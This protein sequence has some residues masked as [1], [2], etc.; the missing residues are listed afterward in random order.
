MSSEDSSVQL[1]I[2]AEIKEYFEIEKQLKTVKKT[3][4]LLNKRR[5]E[6]AQILTNC[7]K[8][9]DVNHFKTD[10]GYISIEEKE[11]S[12]S[13]NK[14]LIHQIL[15]EQLEEELAKELAEN[16]FKNRPKK[17]STAIRVTTED[18]LRRHV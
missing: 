17:T 9:N 13:V 16:V 12:Q 8:E 6:L 1:N 15:L 2:G 14:D 18:E 7:M 10:Q 11:T 4:S 3:V 5:K